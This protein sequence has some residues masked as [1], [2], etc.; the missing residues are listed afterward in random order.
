MTTVRQQ[1]FDVAAN[2]APF[3]ALVPDGAAAL[4]GSDTAPD[5]PPALKTAPWFYLELLSQ[6]GSFS[7]DPNYLEGGFRWWGYDLPHA[8]WVRL[9][10]AMGKLVTAPGYRASAADAAAPYVDSDTGEVVLTQRPI[11]FGVE[12]EDQERGLNLLT[13]TWQLRMRFRGEWP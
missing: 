4:F 12:T 2:Y 10:K 11:G 3:M 8:G 9:R 13:F 1:I 5:P 7:G 6:T